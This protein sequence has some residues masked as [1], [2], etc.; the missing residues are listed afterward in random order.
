MRSRTP[1]PCR[2][3]SRSRRTS[4][5][6]AV[7]LIVGLAVSTLV[8]VGVYQVFVPVLLFARSSNDRLS[9]QQDVRLAMDRMARDLRESQMAVSRLRIYGGTAIGLVTAR[10]FCTGPFAINAGSGTPDWQAVIYIVRHAPSGELRRYCDTTSTFTAAAPVVVGAYNL[11]ARNVQAVTFTPD[12]PTISA[13][14]SVTI[15]LH[16]RTPRGEA[17]RYIRT[18]FVPLND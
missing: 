15:A 16:E 1:A 18:E 11:M 6:A 7:D 5:F 14:T 4:G 17:N 10:P 9:V 2:P 3:V 13:A 12:A 8:M